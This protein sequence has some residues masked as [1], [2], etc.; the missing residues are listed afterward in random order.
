MHEFSAL[1]PSHYCNPSPQ[2]HPPCKQ[3]L[4]CHGNPVGPRLSQPCSHWKEGSGSLS[5]SAGCGNWLGVSNHPPPTFQNTH[6]HT[7]KREHICTNNA[8]ECTD[9]IYLEPNVTAKILIKFKLSGFEIVLSICMC[10]VCVHL[11]FLGKTLQQ[12]ICSWNCKKL[13]FFFV[14]EVFYN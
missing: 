11:C 3:P 13:Q 1:T 6:T 5:L 9:G 12:L 4:S 8:A 14:Y 10:S 2:H 7:H